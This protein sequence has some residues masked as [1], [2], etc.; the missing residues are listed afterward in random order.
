MA[1]LT[2]SRVRQGADDLVRVELANI[3]VLSEVPVHPGTSHREGVFRA[4]DYM[5]AGLEL[6]ASDGSW[7]PIALYNP[8]TH[9]IAHQAV[10]DTAVYTDG[11]ALEVPLYGLAAMLE[12]DRLVLPGRS[13]PRLVAD[14]RSTRLA[15][16]AHA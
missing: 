9:Q 6:P 12:D 4:L 8:I 3:G 11:A 15:L 10:P 2:I 1:Q 13:I 16:A 5:L 7:R 14:T